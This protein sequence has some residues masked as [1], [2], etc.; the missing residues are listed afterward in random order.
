M[1]KLVYLALVGTVSYQNVQAIKFNADM[2]DSDY[3]K[4]DDSLLQ[5]VENQNSTTVAIS[6]STANQTLSQINLTSNA[7]LAKNTSSNV[8]TKDDDLEAYMK[9][10]DDAYFKEFLH[11]KSN[12]TANAT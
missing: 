12:K 7:T 4:T 8:T 11:K 1:N 5:T 9:H 3:E 10:N 2:F 6:N